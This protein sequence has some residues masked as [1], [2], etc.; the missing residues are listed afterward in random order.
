MSLSKRSLGL[1]IKTVVPSKRPLPFIFN[2][3]TPRRKRP[4]WGL[5]PILTCDQRDAGPEW[6]I[7]FKPAYVNSTKRLLPV[8]PTASSQR[9][10]GPKRQQLSLLTKVF[11]ARER[12][13]RLPR[14]SSPR[15]GAAQ[16]YPTNNEIWMFNSKMTRKSAKS[17][18]K[19]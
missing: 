15:C 10:D 8:A 18:P 1:T 12:S 19:D 9:D 11:G 13:E 4:A 17:I 14:N 6:K 2:Q 5:D 3:R 7:L 16:A